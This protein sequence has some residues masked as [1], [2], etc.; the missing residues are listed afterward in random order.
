[1]ACTVTSVILYIWLGEVL[2][3][4]MDLALLVWDK[5]NFFL[6]FL[7]GFCSWGY[8]WIHL[9]LGLQFILPLMGFSKED[10]Q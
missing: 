8:F 10:I 2:M 1:M 6:A 4:L 5:M 3:L 9:D 7:I